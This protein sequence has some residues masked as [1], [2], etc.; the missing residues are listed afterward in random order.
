MI[1]LPNTDSPKSDHSTTVDKSGDRVKQMFGEISTQY[2]RMN[3]VL[4]GGVDYYWRAYTVRKVP[5]IG[6]DP[7][8]DVCT[9]TGDLAIAYWNST[10]QKTRVVGTD[11]TPEMLVIARQKAEKARKNGGTKLEFI[12]SDTQSLPF[13]DSEFQLVTVAFGLRNVSDTHAGLREMIRVCKPGGRVAVL[14]FSQPTMPVLAGLYRWYFKNILPRIGQLFAKNRQD[15]YN[16]LPQSV[17]EFPYGKELADIMT[18][19]GL[20]KVTFTPLTFGIA[21]LYVGQ[22]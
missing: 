1:Q 20:K 16:Y 18:Q 22:K 19:C 11:F 7:I 3:H 10:K 13:Q 21:T 12:E 15:A 4:S 6:N 8:L 17:S 14:E 2:D 9:G 5:A